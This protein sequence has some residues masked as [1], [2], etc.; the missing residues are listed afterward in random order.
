MTII[1]FKT[2][3][4]TPNLKPVRPKIIFC[5]LCFVLYVKKECLGAG[6]RGGDA[7]ERGGGGGLLGGCFE[8]FFSDKHFC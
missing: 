8:L 3:K 2:S 5:T 4:L 7:K 6:G 1:S